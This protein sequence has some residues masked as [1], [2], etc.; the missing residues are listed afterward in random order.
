LK[1][2]SDPFEASTVIR[3]ST[4]SSIVQGRGLTPFSTRSNAKKLQ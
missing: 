4:S 2:G 3:V 1:K